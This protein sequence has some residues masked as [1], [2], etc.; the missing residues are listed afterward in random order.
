MQV[1]GD[2][3]AFRRWEPSYNANGDYV[4]ATRRSTSSISSNPDAP[5]LASTVITDDPDGWWGNMRVV[6]DTLYTTHYEW[7]DTPRRTATQ[8]LDVKYYLDRI[9]LTDRAHPR[10]GAKINVPGLLVGASPAIRRSSTPSTTAGTANNAENDFDVLRIRRL[11]GDLLSHDAS[12]AGSVDLRARDT[13]VHVA[14]SSTTPT[15]NGYDYAPSSCT[16]ST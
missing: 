11:H 6:G 3:L 12:T 4:D 7:I 5:T 13:G 1:G 9:D 10:V 8:R 15:S 2:A 16:R 14:R